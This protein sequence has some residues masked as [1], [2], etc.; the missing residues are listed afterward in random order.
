MFAGK[1]KLLEAH[2]ELIG[3]AIQEGI[4][5]H[6]QDAKQIDQH[7]ASISRAID[8]GAYSFVQGYVKHL[9]SS[10][11]E[12]VW[13]RLT[14]AQKSS[15]RHWQKNHQN[16]NQPTTPTYVTKTI[17][18]FVPDREVAKPPVT[19]NT[20]PSVAVNVNVDVKEPPTF[21][22]PIVKVKEKSIPQPNQKT[23]LPGRYQVGDM[24]KYVGDNAV[25][26][27]QYAGKLVVHSFG[28]G[29]VCILTPNGRISTW[30]DYDEITKI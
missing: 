15:Y 24:V 27:Q 9:N 3:L 25:S 21:E 4:D 16:I 7:V 1:P 23:S 26:R 13:N 19:Y 14:N 20:A 18:T 29:K 8:M 30:L 2:M 10:A 28:Y 17:K 12:R 11:K 6:S 22:K 5:Y